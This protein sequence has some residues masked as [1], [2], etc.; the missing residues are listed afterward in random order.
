MK[1][2]RTARVFTAVL[3]GVAVA[4]CASTVYE[5]KYDWAEG[6]RKAKVVKVQ[7]PAEMLRPGFYTCVRNLSSEQRTT[8]RFAL[9]EYRRVSRTFRHAALV[10]QGDQVAEGDTVYV[11]VDDCA[12]PLATA[13]DKTKS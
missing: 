8:Q 6:W 7:T 11:D 10:R 2:L 1:P 13:A 5:G 4:G 3:A 12:R 9:V